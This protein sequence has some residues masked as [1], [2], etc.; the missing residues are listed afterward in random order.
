MAADWKE[1]QE[2]A[3]TFFRSLGMDGETN[4]TL[5]GVRTAHDVDVRVKSH[6]VGFDITWIVE[7]KQ[8]N[9]KVSKLHV[10]GLR[11]IV[12]DVGADRGILLSESGFQSGAT[13]AAALTNVHITSLA[14]LRGTASAEIYAMRLRELYDRIEKCTEQYWDIDKD[15][16]IAS[17]LRHDVYEYGYS[18][19]RTIKIVEELLRKAFRGAYPFEPD[20]FAQVAVP[21]LPARFDSVATVVAA[22]EPLVVEL[23]AKLKA[24]FD[25]LK[26]PT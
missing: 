17:G 25:S 13:E 8:W 3:A 23:E 26:P 11:Q 20:E 2:E 10:L 14:N 21:S 19:A 16:R 4:V 6:H 15:E 24:Y 22:I 18:G 9:S 5:Q 7:C 1:Y 12:T